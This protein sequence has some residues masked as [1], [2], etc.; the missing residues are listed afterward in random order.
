MAIT[1]H[2]V[3]GLIGAALNSST[4]MSNRLASLA[5]MGESSLSQG[6]SEKLD[7]L[8]AIPAMRE[9]LGSRQ[10]A[11]PIE[12]NYQVLMTLFETSLQMPLAWIEDDKTGLVQQRIGQ[13]VL[14]RE[15]LYGALIAS[16]INT[17][18]TC[19]DGQ[20]FFSDTHSW[21]SS[22]TLDNNVTSAATT[23]TAPTASEAATGIMAGWQTLLGML[24][25]RGQPV[26]ENISKIAV[27]CGV[28][29]A[30]SHQIAI[31]ANNL[32]TGT[33]VRDN[34]V[35]G[36]RA[37]GVEVELIASPRLTDTDGI[38]VI[39]R[40]PG[41]APFA[42]LRNPKSLKTT[43]KAEGSDFEHDQNA[44]AFGV[45]ETVA[46]GYGLF[47]DACLVTYV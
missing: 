32:D 27:C 13:I 36:L 20:N 40:S 15:S 3:L 39:N 7:F 10:D 46:S 42:I 12:H 26:N 16:L 29:L 25:D 43:A 21:G 37:A 4:P 9:W 5:F 31:T 14:R 45:K 23:A 2:G 8:G 30:A 24:D 17:N 1:S 35:Q 44:W 6:Q 18:G 41:A 19:F 28:S 22:G 11:Q 38:A 33:G 34:P 47:T